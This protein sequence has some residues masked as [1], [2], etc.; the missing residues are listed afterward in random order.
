MDDAKPNYQERLQMRTIYKD[1]A[2]RNKWYANLKK[3][4]F[5]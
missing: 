4:K 1:L 3:G 2:M 5:F